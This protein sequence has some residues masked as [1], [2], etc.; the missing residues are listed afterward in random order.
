MKK[1]FVRLLCC[2]VPG[3]KNRHKIREYFCNHQI[4][5]EKQNQSIETIVGSLHERINSL[6][7]LIKTAVNVSNVLPAKGH[8][9]LIQK[10]GISILS[11]FAKVANK[12]GI[13]FWLDSGTL[14][15]FVRHNGFIPWDDDIDI[16]VS[17]DDY[18]KLPKLLDKEFCKNGFFYRVGDITRLYYKQLRVW[19]DIF[20]FDVGYSV[21]VPT[22]QEYKHFIQILDDIKKQSDFDYMKWLKLETPV[23]D[24]YLQKCFQCRDKELVPNKVK[25]G[26]LF[27]GVETGVQ[28]RVLYKNDVVYPLQPVTFFGIKTF[29]P[30]NYD[31][32]LFRQ[33]GDYMNWPKNFNS[34]HGTSLAENMD[35][36]SYRLCHELINKFYPYKQS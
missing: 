8:M 16:C 1:F 33:Y 3:R 28:N 18:E 12:H 26:F 17:R 2:F 35:E 6:E 36:Q 5:L 23:S 22:G 31:E 14:I 13:K 15:G 21:N 25:N 30:N 4:N 32:Y 24:T 7:Q 10:S 29:V 27:F 9:E 19:V 34:I 20:P 11:Q